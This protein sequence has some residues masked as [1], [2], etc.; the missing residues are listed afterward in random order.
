MTARADTAIAVCVVGAMVA[1]LA[2]VTLGAINSRRIDDAPSRASV[3]VVRDAAA[4]CEQRT[5]DLWRAQDALAQRVTAIEHAADRAGD[6][7]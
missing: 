4:V 7:R 5:R 6:G 2:A 3:A 1:S